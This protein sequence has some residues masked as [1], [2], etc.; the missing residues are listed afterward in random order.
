VDSLFAKDLHQDLKELSAG[1]TD[2][3]E[4][5]DWNFEAGTD[6]NQSQAPNSPRTRTAL[7]R[8]VSL[9]EQWG[10]P[11]AANAYRELNGQK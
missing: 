9:Y 2:Y 8:V 1:Y 10:K 7:L 4:K 11:D 6:P 3:A 5:T